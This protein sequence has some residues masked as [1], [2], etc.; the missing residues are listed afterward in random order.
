MFVLKNASA[1]L[2]RHGWRTGAM[3]ITAVAIASLTIFSNSVIDAAHTASTTTYNAQKPTAVIRPTQKTLSTRNGAD[4]SWTKNHLSWT[5][6]T[7]YATAVQSAN[8]EFSYTFTETIPVRQSSS[9]KAIKASTS[10]SA[11]KTGGDL[12]WRSFY[13]L[14]AAQSNDFG[15]FKIVSGKH[16]NYKGQDKSSILISQA[17][18]SKNNLKV[19]STITVANPTDS[20]KTYK[21]KVRGIYEYV[22]TAQEGEGSDAKFAKDNRDNAIYSTYYTFGVNGLDISDGKG[23]SI[24]DLNIMFQLSSVKNYNSFVK[25]VKKAE[26]PRKYEV[27]SPSLEKYETGIQ[28]LTQWASRMQ[29][30]RIVVWS[31]GGLIL[32]VLT[33]LTIIRRRGEI[34]TAMLV[35]VSRGRIAWQ[36]MVESLIPTILGLALGTLI[37]GVATPGVGMSL[38]S[39]STPMHSTLIWMILGCGF[40]ACVALAIVSTI[41]VITLRKSTLVKPPVH[42]PAPSTA[43]TAAVTD[44][45]ADETPTPKEEAR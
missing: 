26:L 15:R 12:T 43:T 19:G 3:A 38:T 41:P 30:T 6:Y 33:I 10:T 8:V 22:G 9:I 45:H 1:T 20:S 24:P 5:N 36:F 35:G 17:V 42:T 4:S 7:T 28:P 23:W 11:D 44:K 25:A 32:L 21:L 29:T 40:A 18:A 2:V 34:A 14:E 37:G 27:T 13:T 39:N 31:A 16:L